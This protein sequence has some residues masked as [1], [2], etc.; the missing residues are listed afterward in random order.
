MLGDK[1]IFSSFPCDCF[2]QVFAQLSSCP[3]PLPPSQN[4]S[5]KFSQRLLL[6]RIFIK[7]YRL[8]INLMTALLYNIFALLDET[9]R[10]RFELSPLRPQVCI[11]SLV[12]CGE[13][14]IQR[15]H[16][17]QRNSLT[18]TSKCIHSLAVWSKLCVLR[19]LTGQH[20]MYSKLLT[21]FAI[22]HPHHYAVQ[23]MSPTKLLLISQL[24]QVSAFL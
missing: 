19:K 8:Y 22:I 13:F 23:F 6:C 18:F 4:K 3:P 14:P 21:S 20:V 16:G 17:S 9:V 12:H 1:Q 7:L 10:W 24:F 2:C 5:Q 11:T 15:I